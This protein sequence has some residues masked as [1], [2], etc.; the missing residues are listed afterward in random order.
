MP[1]KAEIVGNMLK[2]KCDTPAQVLDEARALA[3]LPAEAVESRLQVLRSRYR[4]AAPL[5]TPEALRLLRE[6]GERVRKARAADCDGRALATLKEVFG[7]PQFRAGQLEIIH[8][9]MA[10]RDCLG[11]MPT[12]AGKSVTFQIPARLLGGVTLVV[13]PLISLMKDQVDAMGEVGIRATSLNSSLDPA[14]RSPG[15]L[16]VRLT[17]DMF[18]WF[19]PQE[20]Q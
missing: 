5:F 3:A 6:A 18:P 12:G 11:V 15:A 1:R 4:E 14:E 20:A 17:L 9:V 10:G 13:S 19:G 16:P 7:Y 8:A 2:A